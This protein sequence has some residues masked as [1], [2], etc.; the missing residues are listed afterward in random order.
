VLAH[1]PPVARLTLRRSG[2][3][4]KRLLVAHLDNRQAVRVLAGKDRSEHDHV[5]TLEAWLPAGTRTV[6]QSALETGGGG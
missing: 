5:A 6:V 1:P 4:A 2:E 3:L